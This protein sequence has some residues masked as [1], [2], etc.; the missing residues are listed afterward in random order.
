MVKMMQGMK[1]QLALLHII[2]CKL[3]FKVISPGG[4]ALSSFDVREC[5][6]KAVDIALGKPLYIDVHLGIDISTAQV[7]YANE[8]PA[9]ALLRALDQRQV[10]LGQSVKVRVKA[11]RRRTRR[12]LSSWKGGE[13]DFLEEG[14][15]DVGLQEARQGKKCI[16]KIPD[17]L[18]LRR[19]PCK[20]FRITVSD[21]QI[22]LS[23]SQTAS[24]R[25]Q[26]EQL[27]KTDPTQVEA[28]LLSDGLSMDIYV[29][30]EGKQAEMEGVI[31]KLQS[32][33][34]SCEHSTIILP[35]LV[36]V[37]RSGFFTEA[38]KRNRRA[39]HERKLKELQELRKQYQEQSQERQE[40][41]ALLQTLLLESGGE[42]VEGRVTRSLNK[43]LEGIGIKLVEAEKEGKL[44]EG[45]RR[46]SV[47]SE[48][49][50]KSSLMLGE[51][52]TSLANIQ[53]E[54]KLL[55]E[56]AKEQQRLERIRDVRVA[57]AKTLKALARRWRERLKDFGL[58]G[59]DMNELCRP[60]IDDVEEALTRA[61]DLV[62]KEAHK[63]INL[64]EYFQRLQVSLQNVDAMMIEAFQLLQLDEDARVLEAGM[65]GLCG[66]LEK[67]GEDAVYDGTKFGNNCSAGSRMG[68]VRVLPRFLD[69]PAPKAAYQQALSAASLLNTLRQSKDFDAGNERVESF[70][71]ASR[72]LADN[73][74]KLLRPAWEF[75]VNLRKFELNFIRLWSSANLKQKEECSGVN[76]ELPAALA[77]ARAAT[78]EAMHAACAKLQSFTE[79]SETAQEELEDL[80]L[81]LKQTER[82]AGRAICDQ[83][84]KERMQKEL[85]LRL[86]EEKIL[87]KRIRE[88]EVR[89]KAQRE[90]SNMINLERLER[91]RIFLET[92]LRIETSRER[93]GHLRKSSVLACRKRPHRLLSEKNNLDTTQG[94]IAALGLKGSRAVVVAA[95][96]TIEENE[97]WKMADGADCPP[98]QF[99]FPGHPL[100]LV[101]A[102]FREKSGRLSVERAEC[103]RDF[104]ELG[105][106][107]YLHGEVFVPESKGKAAKGLP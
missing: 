85:R 44:A 71:V 25:K 82:E 97:R 41:L 68:L 64:E 21:E 15:V 74:R 95:G 28:L 63:I 45:Q 105:Y 12:L 4:K 76:V 39:A 86:A 30:Y 92:S 66:D 1:R 24:L 48:K 27:I 67:S 61:R 29:Q 16:E 70:R 7:A 2:A 94:C 75:Y 78:K 22:P 10:I 56:E 73:Y 90:E 14:E 91:R 52:R 79:T 23:F 46:T 34:L 43:E 32:K 17:T 54:M 80:L 57:Q 88:R 53:G 98:R 107:G 60:F 49:L 5:V 101:S 20:W 102:E 106:A 99:E 50:K 3:E 35:L 58:P 69:C 19:L 100:N 42:A 36:D 51:C 72:Q 55:R 87:K 38:Q 18:V 104:R 93:L 33:A 26:V 103:Q 13:E 96:G 31:A 8:P 11:Q 47:I 6:M 83:R 62:L 81:R 65:T 89:V 77:H 84:E 37:D 40:L 9:D 59:R